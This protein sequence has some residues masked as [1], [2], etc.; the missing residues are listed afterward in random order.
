M[1]LADIIAAIRVEIVEPVEGY[2]RD[3]QLTRYVNDGLRDLNDVAKVIAT[4]PLTYT[5][6]AHQAALPS[7]FYEAYRVQWDGAGFLTDMQTGAIPNTTTRGT[8]TG[9]VVTPAHLHLWPVPA[10]AGTVNLVYFRRLP[11]LVGA[12]DVP[13]IPEHWRSLLV[14]YAAGLA[15]L[16]AGEPE[17]PSFMSQYMAGKQQYAHERAQA[18]VIAMNTPNV[19][20]APGS[21]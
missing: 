4:V 7:D 15:K 1:T 16:F 3:S 14:Y 21:D 11:A 6:G 2:W 8:P 17:G 10:Q 5:A 9:Y 18:T 13:A 19:L 20:D 12:T